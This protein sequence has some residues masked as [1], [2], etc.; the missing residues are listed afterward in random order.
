MRPQL[1]E[2]PGLFQVLEQTPARARRRD[3]Q[4]SKAAAGSVPVADLEARVL[5]TLRNHPG[6][7]T[8]HEVARLL[9]MELVSVSP[10]FRPL[11]E[12]NLVL[13]TAARRK[14]PSGRT[15]IVWKAVMP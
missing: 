8:S 1:A 6:G 13:P 7:L 10:R 9:N 5:E 2:Q 4:T 15:S 3:P 12:K 11:A 14:G